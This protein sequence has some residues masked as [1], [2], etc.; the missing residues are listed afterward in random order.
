M[1]NYCDNSVTLQHEDKAK[2][3]AL[4]AELSKKSEGHY[5]SQGQL[6]EFLR[7]NPSGEWQYDWSCENWGSIADVTFDECKMFNAINRAL[8]GS[9]GK[10]AP[11]RWNGC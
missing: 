10:S 11:F 6:F 8:V 2:I 3:D 5:G 4:D 9:T 7:P 1:P